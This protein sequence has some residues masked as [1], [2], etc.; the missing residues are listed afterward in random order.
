MRLPILTGVHLVDI[1]GKLGIDFGDLPSQPK[2]AE[3]FFIVKVI[4]HWKIY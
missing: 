3:R 4:F 2:D 1:D